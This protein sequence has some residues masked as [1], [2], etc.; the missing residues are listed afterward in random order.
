[1]KV[2]KIIKSRNPVKKEE[3]FLLVDDEGGKDP[4]LDEN[5]S[6]S[7]TPDRKG[8][9]RPFMF[10]TWTESEKEFDAHSWLMVYAVKV[11]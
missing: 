5:W 4:E 7:K 3:K 1:M 11:D 8:I 10:G 2:Y 9:T 6:L